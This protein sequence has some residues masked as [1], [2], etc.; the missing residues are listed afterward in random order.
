MG[1]NCF[2]NTLLYSSPSHGD[3]GIV[4]IAAQ[5][6]ESQILFVCPFACGRHGALGAMQ[7]G[8]KDRVSY[9][10][11]DQE[12][13]IAGYDALIEQAVDELLARRS[14]RAVYIYVSCLDDLIGTDLDSLCLRLDRAHPGLPFR[15]GHM[16][17]ITLESKSPPMMTTMRAMFDFLAPREDRDAGVNLIANLEP[18]A[19]ECE[20]FDALRALGA[21][22]VRHITD[23]DTFEGYQQMAKS[24]K[25]LVLAPYGA[26]AA[27]AM[28]K[29]HG[30]PYCM[31]PVTYDLEQIDAQYA[32]IAQFLGGTLPDMGMC[33]RRAEEAMRRAREAL[34]GR[35]VWITAGSVA[36]PF[37]LARALSRAGFAV[38]AVV[39]QTVLPID[40]E[41]Y[42]W[43]CESAPQIRVYQP[44]HARLID[45]D[46]R[47][48]EAV[49]IGFD[50][51]Y[52]AGTEHVAPVAM[53]AGL[54]GYDGVVR[55]MDELVRA[56]EER[57]DL[58]G[59]IDA[60]GAV[61]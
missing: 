10:Y 15:A 53:D 12:D 17:P 35:P 11:I 54:F 25:N 18:I 26:L 33:R 4:R 49:A 5:V 60:Y 51:A 13:I 16:N 24:A 19:P 44:Q 50:A 61:I 9:L 27:E 22:P 42:D 2:E 45:F 55:L 40:R 3:W 56:A 32:Q 59:L 57:R 36:K 6:P 52:I 39:A 31:L 20:L 41:G 28:R 7:H 23:F 58:K 34:S 47:D 14:P 37:A 48:P 29:K 38:G 30:M 1:C 21:Q 46:H 8:F 43:L